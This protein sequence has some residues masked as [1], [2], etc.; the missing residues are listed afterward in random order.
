MKGGLFLGSSQD[1]D[2][3]AAARREPSAGPARRPERSAG[4]RG[5][6][7]PKPDAATAKALAHF[8]RATGA[9]HAFQVVAE[10]LWEPVDCFQ[11]RTP[12]AVPA[13]TFLSQLL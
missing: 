9:E 4:A 11:W 2:Q 13:R 1:K 12:V 7:K 8:Q 5:A 3:R 10:M 6:G